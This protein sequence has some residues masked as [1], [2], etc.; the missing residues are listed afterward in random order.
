MHGDLAARNILLDENPLKGRYPVAKVADF[1][2]SKMFKEYETYEKETR[3]FVPWRWMALEYLNDSYF[4]M[5]SDVWSFGV[6]LW[7][8]FSFGKT[9]YGHQ[10]YDEVLLRL[11]NGYR[12]P[13][14]NEIDK[15][16]TWTP[17]S[18]Y[19]Q[20][21]G[22]CFVSDYHNRAS[23][24]DILTIISSKLT[25]EEK[26]VHIEMKEKYLSTRTANYLKINRIEKI[27]N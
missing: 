19:K 9:P 10:G 4:T 23:F 16:K 3:L 25:V 12:L 27:E 13:C 15:I 17:N 11:Q 24:S 6:L 2:L 21:S 26:S 8:I 20:I 18:L 22:L 14:P 5:K 7:E 1:G